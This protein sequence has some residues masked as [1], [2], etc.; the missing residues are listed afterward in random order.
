MGKA[1]ARGWCTS[2]LSP[3]ALVVLDRHPEKRAAFYDAVSCRFVTSQ[4]ALLE[5]TPAAICFA[6]KPHQLVE[7][8]GEIKSGFAAAGPLVLSVIAGK[9]IADY[10]AALWPGTAVIR[11]MPN[12]PSAIGEGMTGCFANAH[13]SAS[14]RDAAD[15]LMCSVGQTLWLKDE[16]QMHALT[17]ISGSGPAYVF[18][19]MECL[20]DAAV[21]QGFDADEAR[22]LAEQTFIG[23]AQMAGQSDVSLDALRAQV[24]SPGGT[25]E[26]GLD[27]LMTSTIG[28]ILE[29]TVGAAKRRSETL[30]SPD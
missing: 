5:T 20:V 19:L 21:K 25:T 15:Q 11:L 14:Q 28:R 18:Y 4:A 12:T 2:A 3:E 13:V 24:T 9:G 1:L 17:A 30:M 23:A 10:E 26:A 29:D 6:V 22:L 8:L 27:V 16:A 7:V